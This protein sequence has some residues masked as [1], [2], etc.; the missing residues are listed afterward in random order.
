MPEPV[1]QLLQIIT[2]A[3]EQVAAGEL[4][5][6]LQ[7]FRSKPDFPDPEQLVLQLLARWNTAEREVL[8]NLMSEDDFRVERAQITKRLLS[9]LQ[10]T[11]LQITTESTSAGNSDAKEVVPPDY[12]GKPQVLI[13]YAEEDQSIQEELKKH[14]FVAM[15]DTALQFIDIHEAVPL[16]AP[17]RLSYQR[18][19]VEN[20]RVVLAL[21]SPNILTPAVFELAETA[22]AS[23]KLIPIRVEEVSI[24]RTP[25]RA[26]IKGLPHDGRFVSAWPDRNT[27]WVGIAQALQALFDQ[28]K[29]ER[30]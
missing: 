24:E 11:R 28:I 22:S 10:E 25:F 16:L 29:E 19:L 30:A 3:E 9:F 23:G 2:Q 17:D 13:L 4:K 26:E 14:L 7:L 27:A 5:R 1:E 21:V 15:R 6:A 18:Q 8:E 12:D 20:A